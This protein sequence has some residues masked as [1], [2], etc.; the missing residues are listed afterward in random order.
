[1]GNGHKFGNN[2]HIWT[3]VQLKSSWLSTNHFS[4]RHFGV[5]IYFVFVQNEQVFRTANKNAYMA[6]LNIIVSVLNMYPAI[7]IVFFFIGLDGLLPT[8]YRKDLN[9]FAVQFIILTV[10]IK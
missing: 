5:Q 10:S 1:M 7:L 6:F 2:L 9:L 4:F 8:I 3:I